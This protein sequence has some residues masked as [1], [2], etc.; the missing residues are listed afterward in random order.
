MPGRRRPPGRDRRR[1]PSAAPGATWASRGLPVIFDLPP[2]LAVKRADEF[3]RD[4]HPVLQT[5]CARC[6]NEQLPGQFQLIEVKTRHGPDGRRP[7]RQPRRDPPADRPRQPGPERAALQRARPARQRP[8]P[9]ADLPGVER[10]RLPDHRRLGQ[11][12]PTRRPAGRRRRSDPVRADGADR[13]RADG[14]AVDR[15]AGPGAVPGVTTVPPAP[16]RPRP[17]PASDRKESCRPT[18]C[19]PRPG[20]GRREAVRALRPRSSPPRTCSAALG[21]SPSRRRRPPL[22][23][24]PGRRPAARTVPPS[25]RVA[26]HPRPRP[27]PPASPTPTAERREARQA[28]PGLL[29][30]RS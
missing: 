13:R 23:T 5:A 29:E 8:E 21:P 9:A 15:G 17:S 28:R 1:R 19:R 11:Q 24:R 18:R 22:P 30:R 27:R 2:A 14:F 3:A 12:P 4:V 6:H 10:P 25:R 16:T 26:A 20:H 7:P